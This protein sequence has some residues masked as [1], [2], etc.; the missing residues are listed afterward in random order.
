MIK[1]NLSPEPRVLRQFAWV[2]LFGLPLLT[3]FVVK[4]ARGQ[5]WS[6]VE[7][8]SD[9]AVLA[10]LALAAVALIALELGSGALARALFVT[11]SAVAIPIGFVVSHVL[12]ALVYYFVVTPIAMVFRLTGRDVLG[13]RLDPGMTSYW[14]ERRGARSASSY[15]KLY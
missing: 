4:T 11:L 7:L 1:I 12:I 14:H 2:G 13:K 10:V 6:D 9:A 3:A 15:F 5:A 8:W